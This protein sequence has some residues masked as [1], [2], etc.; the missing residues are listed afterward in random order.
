MFFDKINKIVFGGNAF[1]KGFQKSIDSQSDFLNSLPQPL[2]LFQRSYNQYQC[3]KF[4][5]NQSLVKRL[6]LIIACS[7]IIP[8]F[9]LFYF[10]R[11][12]FSKRGKENEEIAVFPYKGRYGQI[13]PDSILNKYN[14]VEID[15]GQSHLLTKESAS[16]CF[17]LII[18]YWT[19]PVFVLKTLYKVAFYNFIIHKYDCKAIIGSNEYSFSSSILTEFCRENGVSHINVMHGEKLYSIID[20]WFEFDRFYVWDQHYIDLFI[21]LKAS[22]NQFEVSVPQN[23]RLDIQKG[24]EI[25][26]LTYYLAGEG[27]EL[28]HAIYENLKKLDNQ[29]IC[30][31]FHPRYNEYSK[32]KSIFGEYP[33]ENP[34]EISLKKSFESTLNISALFSTVL[35]QGY[36][37]GKNVLIDD[38]SHNQEELDS[39]KEMRYILLEKNVDYLSKVVSNENCIY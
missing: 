1:G 8:F 27:E 21:S 16:I 10:L 23:L 36:L 19:S 17:N 11:G 39:L 38:L 34:S 6:I 30:I 5:Q 4:I 14:I 28:M 22:K 20:S 2:D 32:V 12:W 24:N 18:K 13:I 29:K 26:F 3:Q 25:Y 7:V 35:L 37:N 9:L 31:R 15:F 33:I